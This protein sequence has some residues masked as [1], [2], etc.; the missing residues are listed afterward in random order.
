MMKKYKL[1]FIVFVFMTVL[2]GCAE[3]KI[4]E[5]L[6]LATLIGYDGG[7]GE[8]IT[9]TAIIRQVNPEFE[10]NVETLSATART[11]K[12]TREQVSAQVSKKVT[13]GQLRVVLFGE[14]LATAGIRQSIY[15]LLMNPEISNGIYLGVVEGEAKP[16]LEYQYENI[17]DISQH[18]FNLLEHNIE[19]ENSISSTLHE[20]GRDYYSPTRQIV[21]PIIKRKENVIEITGVAFFRSEYMVGRLPAK[22]IFYVKMI[23]DGFEK[24]TFELVLDGENFESV[25]TGETP[26]ELAIAL[27]AIKTK[28]TIKLIDQNTPEYDL[29]FKISVRLTEID[30]SIHTGDK[31]TLEM[32]EKEINKKMES[33]LSRIIQ[34]TQEIDSDVFGFGE[35]YESRV[36]DSN[37]THEELAEMYS[38]MKV[39][40]QVKSEIIR[41][42]VFGME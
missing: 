8:N 35:H 4:L 12:G 1:I 14:E 29:N 28:K 20:I 31:K 25:S 6:S 23:R 5:R 15:T 3:Q 42:G 7:E 33:E 9:A 22:D 2:G 34:F 24:G 18:I 16:F 40:V 13:V 26:E 27:D 38:N 11:S 32:L 39:N 36:S 37:L 30:A 17:T 21:M 41:D 19:R 10:S